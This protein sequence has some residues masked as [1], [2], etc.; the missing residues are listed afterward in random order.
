MNF[1]EA[2]AKARTN[3]RNL[4]IL[5][6]LAVATL[7]VATNL[8][9]MFFL[10]VNQNDGNIDL[11]F[12]EIF[13]HFDWN[14]FFIISVVII[15]FVAITS[16]IKRVQL[17]A[18][19][20][21]IAEKLGGKLIH[22]DTKDFHEKQ[23]LNVVTE[24]SIAS[25]IPVPPVYLIEEKSI[26]AFAAGFGINDA[27]IGI[28]RGTI[29]NLNRE[30]LQGVIAHE[31]SHIF[32]GDMRINIRLIAILHGI[33]IIGI[34]GYHILRS[35]KYRKSGGGKDQGKGIA[36]IALLG[37]GLMVIGYAGTFF[38]NLIKASIS[39]KRECLADASAVQFTRN[40]TGVASALKK[41]GSSIYGSKI[42]NPEASE[43]SHMF[44]AE[45]ISNIFGSLMATHPPLRERILAIDP[46]WN[47]EFPALSEDANLKNESK[48]QSKT[49]N[50]QN[51]TIFATSIV[52]S[53]INKI[54]V[55]DEEA[56][57][58]SHNIIK[59]IE[60]RVSFQSAI[61]NPLSARSVIFSL[62]IHDQINQLPILKNNLD[63]KTFKLTSD[64]Y[65]QN[66]FI[67]KNI[68]LAMI[69][70]AIP[71]LKELSIDDYKN[72]KQ[73][74]KLLVMSDSKIDL[75]EWSIGKIVFD[76]LDKQ[77]NKKYDSEEG[78]HKLQDLKEDIGLILS[79]MSSVENKDENLAKKIF[80]DVIKEQEIT[81]LNFTENNKIKIS[82]INKAAENLK[83]L[84]PLEKEKFLKM[85]ISCISGNGKSSS[86]IEVFRAFATTLNCPV[87]L[88]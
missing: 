58:K 62:L 15:S 17:S 81:D 71:T 84:A 28:T 38:G 44:F 73:I 2:Q 75:F 19:G 64:L 39:R 4:V 77:F 45:G 33:L 78:N 41:I 53:V 21:V 29:K 32:N 66:S 22:P 23:L 57:A 51:K 10:S 70:L 5:F 8:L 88:L 56:V 76:N 60:D 49:S 30:E 34:V 48:S 65:Q 13:N 36:G 85:C 80:E 16:L 72:F 3:T 42:S 35:I 27:V 59:S 9:V 63:E 87:P 69:D 52:G 50:S 24:M 6:L 7:I 83:R 47:G 1:F 31:F 26:N 61:Q 25:G 54:G 37:L 46:S 11:A 12:G 74:V 18:G 67:N 14:L 20:K 55:I 86:E 79:L 40:P 43:V 68:R 82:Q